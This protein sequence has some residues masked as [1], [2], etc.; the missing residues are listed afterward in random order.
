MEYKILSDIGNLRKQNEDFCG[1]E[2]ISDDNEEIGIFIIADGMG[3]HKKGEVASKLAVENTLYFLRKNLIKCNYED[4]NEIT[5]ILKQSYNYANTIVYRTSLYEKEHEGMGTTLTTALVYN[6][7]LYVANIGDSRCYLFRN[8]RLEKI[9]NDNSLIQ[10]LIDKG[11]I[12][13]DEALTHPQRNVITRAIGTD[14]YIKIDFYKEN[15]TKND[16]ILLTTDGLTNSVPI[17]DMEKVLN[18]TI[19]L[20]SCCTKLISLAKDKGGHDNISVICISI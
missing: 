17:E 1:G 19:D 4:E 9:T 8:G 16:K 3:G 14:E 20:D 15:V 11:A 2:I 6:D 7:N 5:S 18:S 13:E 12:T 10:E